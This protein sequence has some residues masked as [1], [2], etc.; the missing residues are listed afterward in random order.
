MVHITAN[1]KGHLV[2]RD[3][4][5][6]VVVGHVDADLREVLLD[7]V[8]RELACFRVCTLAFIRGIRGIS[9][10]KWSSGSRG[11]MIEVEAV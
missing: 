4:G 2:P 1:E 3:H 6:N 11:C 7:L 8:E 10:S 9:R 5:F